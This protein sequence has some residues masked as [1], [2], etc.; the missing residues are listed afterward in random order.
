[1]TE[2]ELLIAEAR[3][4]VGEF[5]LSEAGLTAGSVSAALITESGNLYT[6]ICLDLN[7]GI[8]FCAEHAAIASMLL[9]R[10]TVIKKIV[11]VT[12]CEILPPCGRCRELMLQ[13]DSRN[14]DCDVLLPMGIM[15]KLKEL[16]P[17]D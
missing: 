3:K 13:V 9:N 10:E 5:P 15:R 8:G 2:S 4:Y 1:M 17:Y 12:N 16:L 14:S 7:C 6:G 11:A